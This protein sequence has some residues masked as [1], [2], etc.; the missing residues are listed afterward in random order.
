MAAIQS[1]QLRS[2]VRGG[3]VQPGD[4]SY[5]SARKVYNGMIDKRPAVIVQCVDVA[6][7]IAAVDYAR[8]N[9][10]LTAIRGGGHNGGGLGT[11][12]DGLVI[13]LSAMR[14]VRGR[15][16]RTHRSRGRRLYLGG[17]GPCH[18]SLWSR[19]AEWLHLDDRRGQPHPWRRHRLPHPR[20]RSHHR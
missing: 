5:D 18:A 16:S 20:V 11:C 6:D 14:G 12:D 9:D 8:A 17:C 1:E 13:D 19:R 2:S 10:V 3:I 4:A 15:F 7:V